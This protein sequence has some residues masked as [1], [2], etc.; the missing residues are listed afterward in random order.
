MKFRFDESAIADVHVIVDYYI[1]KERRQ[2]ARFVEDLYYQV[3]LFS[4]NPKLGCELDDDYRRF[5]LKQFPYSVIYEVDPADQ[6]IIIV[7]V[8]HQSRRP[9]YWRGR[10]QEEPAVYALAA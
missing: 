4:L 9:Q 6:T 1:S 2:V 7:A 10:I 3:R 8:Y 5:L